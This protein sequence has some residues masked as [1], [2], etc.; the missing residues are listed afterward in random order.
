MKRMR[1]LSACFATLVA[2][3]ATTPAATTQD[4]N[5]KADASKK[6]MALSLKGVAKK[7]GVK[8][9]HWYIWICSSSADTVTLQGGPSRDD[10]DVFAQWRQGQG[11]RGYA[12]PERAQQ[13][14]VD[15]VF[16]QLTVPDG[17]WH[18]EACVGHDGYA[19]QAYHMNSGGEEHHQNSSGDSDNGCACR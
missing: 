8:D 11:T 6:K 4:A 13:P 19:I 7:R 10:N 18:T 2:V 16:T 12:L 3:A 14:G 1:L 5:T 9:V 15:S 17:P